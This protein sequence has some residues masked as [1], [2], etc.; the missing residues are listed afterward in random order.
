MICLSVN[1]GENMLKK[2]RVTFLMTT[3]LAVTLIV[4]YFVSLYA[5]PVVNYYGIRMRK[6]QLR[7]VVEAHT[8][9]TPNFGLYCQA[10][11]I[12]NLLEQSICFDSQAELDQFIARR[13]QVEHQLTGS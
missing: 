8:P 10:F 11:P 9:T 12:T 5:D 3:I 4:L 6:S 2:R 1:E 13:N 7:Q